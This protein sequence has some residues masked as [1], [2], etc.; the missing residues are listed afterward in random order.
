MTFEQI[1]L[2]ALVP[3]GALLMLAFAH[4]HSKLNPPAR[5]PALPTGASSTKINPR[6]ETHPRTASSTMFGGDKFVVFG[7]QSGNTISGANV[8]ITN[9]HEFELAMKRVLAPKHGRRSGISGR[10]MKLP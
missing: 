1:I 3:V 7:E 9:P 2:M 4:V 10:F 5:R 6:S 8:V